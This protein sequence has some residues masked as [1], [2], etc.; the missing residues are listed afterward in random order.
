MKK[1]T[2]LDPKELLETV[3]KT[4][5][6]FENFRKQVEKQ[7]ASAIKIAEESTVKKFLPLLD[8]LD[9][10]ISSSPALQPLEKSLEKTLKELG[11][12]KVPAETGVEFNPDLH[13]A[14]MVDGDGE[15]ETVAEA[16][17]NGYVYRGEVI[18]P[19]M[20]KVQKSAPEKSSAPEN[21]SEP[22]N[23]AGS[24]QA[25]N[26]EEIDLATPAGS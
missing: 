10:A 12:E 11:L 16:L 18:R 4:R 26:P 25:E 24:G 13:E 23:I 7:R 15:I 3:Q 14:V 2:D 21:S 17:R 6:D 5:A 20:V 9:R 22:E 19:A 1:S 8:D